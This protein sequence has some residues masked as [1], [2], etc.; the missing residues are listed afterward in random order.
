MECVFRRLIAGAVS[1][2][3]VA[4]GFPS[5][6]VKAANAQAHARVQASAGPD[7]PSGNDHLLR[8]AIPAT[9]MANAPPD[10][11][12]TGFTLP[13]EKSKKQITKEIVMWTLI[14]AFV[15]FFIVKVFIEKDNSSTSSGT[16][17][18]PI[19]PPQ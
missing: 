5:H 7:A 13:E 9:L 19:T 2:C 4:A 3:I 15:A 11:S 10:T 17:G 12:D 18:K 16:N 6:G 8:D 1:V 14:A